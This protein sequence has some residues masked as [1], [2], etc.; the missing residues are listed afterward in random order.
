MFIDWLTLSQDFDYDLPVISDTAFLAIDVPTGE[1]LST[2]YKSFKHR[3]SFSSSMTIRINGRRITV[4]GNPSRF[5]RHDNL[6]GF[7]SVEQCVIV[8]NRLLAQYGLPPFTRCTR[9]EIRDGESGGKT[10]HLWADGCVI[11]RID[12]T[13]NIA[14][15]QGNEMDY[16]RSLATQRIG[17]SIGFLYP[18]GRTVDWTTSGHGKGARLQYRKAY[19]KAYELQDKHLPKMKTAYGESSS[20]YKYAQE[21]HE[22]CKSTGIVRLEQELKDEFLSRQK[23]NYWGLFN[24]GEFK[25]IHDEFLNVDQRLTVNKMDM[26]SIAQQLILENIVDT[27]RAANVTAS[28]ALMW[29]QGQ[30]LVCSQRSF[31]T[32]A[33]RLNRIGI[34][35]RNVCDVKSFSTVFIRECREIQPVK[36]VAPP[37]WY[38]RPNH[39]QV[40]A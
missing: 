6:W 11:K 19:D 35:I 25:N 23:L 32:H 31:E 1:V 4:D 8:I 27:P 34:N 22:Y 30:Q 10:S 20:E 38:R 39:L 13:T 12:L 3:G 5:D 37:K 16:I 18:N 40:A 7:E 26:A 15:G 28:Y 9:V 24:E 21:L 29:M 17:H 36:N 2:S 14:V 33:A